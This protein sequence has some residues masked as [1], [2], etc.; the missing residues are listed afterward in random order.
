MRQHTESDSLNHEVDVEIPSGDFDNLIAKSEKSFDAD[1]LIAK[2]DKSFDPD[3]LSPKSDKS[4][5]PEKQT[6]DSWNGKT[7][8]SD[9]ADEPVQNS[10]SEEQAPSAEQEEE[11]GEEEDAMDLPR[12]I[13]HNDT[14][15][16][17]TKEIHTKEIHTTEIQDTK[18]TKHK[19]SAEI[20]ESLH[21]LNVVIMQAT[22]AAE[23]EAARKEGVLQAENEGVSN[24]QAV[25]R[26]TVTRK[27]FLEIFKRTEDTLQNIDEMLHG[28]AGGVDDTCS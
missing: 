14:T 7:S 12:E 21:Q 5:D 16:R 3:N 10:A 27:K 17:Y 6:D 1:N 22:A 25:I 23:A 9:A 20:A 15:P 4:F 19:A 18:I 2:S 24:L 11:E 26:R 28:A 13:F 8:H